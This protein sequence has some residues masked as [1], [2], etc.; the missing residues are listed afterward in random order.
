MQEQNGKRR[1]LAPQ[2]AAG[3]LAVV[4]VAAILS[5]VVPKPSADLVSTGSQ[6]TSSGGRGGPVP[7]RRG[8]S[9]RPLERSQA[10]LRS[11]DLSALRSSI[12]DAVH[13]AVKSLKKGHLA[14]GTP[15][16]ISLK[17]SSER[18]TAPLSPGQKTRIAG[19][20]KL[21][22]GGCASIHS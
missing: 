21:A 14:F 19:E 9:C 18:I 12:H 7:V 2:V 3:V 16:R 20:L 10:A 22:L 1:S 5:F 8:V 13:F 17:L 15:E 11:D 6:Q 4:A